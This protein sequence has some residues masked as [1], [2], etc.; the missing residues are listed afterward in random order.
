[1]TCD[2]DI[3]EPYLSAH[4]ESSRHR[5]LV[6]GSNRV[7]CFYCCTMFNPNEIKEWVDDN[8][9]ALCPY[10]G[11]DSVLHDSEKLNGAFLMEMRKEWFDK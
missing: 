11:I 5:K 8:D 4:R 6:E 3:P 2:L 1:M 9:T 7:G 10:C